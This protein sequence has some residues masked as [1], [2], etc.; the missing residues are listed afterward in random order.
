MY[1]TDFIINMGQQA[2]LATCMGALRILPMSSYSPIDSWDICELAWGKSRFN[3]S[4]SC[5]DCP[6]N[7]VHTVTV[8][9]SCYAPE[10]VNYALLGVIAASCGKDAAWISNFNHTLLRPRSLTT[11]LFGRT[12]YWGKYCW[13]L[14]GY[15]ALRGA[16]NATGALVISEQWLTSERDRA[17]DK[18]K[19]EFAACAACEEKYSGH[20]RAHIKSVAD[21]GRVKFYQVSTSGRIRSKVGGR[22]AFEFGAPVRDCEEW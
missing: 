12:G 4:E 9:G 21:G 18:A 3:N 5:G 22:A 16:M 19:E 15:A 20:L 7:G 8:D 17:C 10:D 11:G 1:I 13:L 14:T 6:K 2:K